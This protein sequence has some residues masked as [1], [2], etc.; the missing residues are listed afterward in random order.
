M[1]KGTGKAFAVSRSAGHGNAL[2]DKSLSSEK[3]FLPETQ[4]VK[5]FDEAWDREDMSETFRKQKMDSMTEMLG[6]T[7]YF[8]KMRWPWLKQ[9]VYGVKYPLEVDRFYQERNLAIDFKEANPDNLETKKTLCKEN[10]IEYALVTTP[11]AFKKLA[12]RLS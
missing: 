5:K 2:A 7:S 8:A 12:Q 3:R 1:A 4:D 6:C 9:E 11:E 10:G